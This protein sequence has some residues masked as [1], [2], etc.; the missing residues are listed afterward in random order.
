ME[1]ITAF[2]DSIKI[3]LTEKNILDIAIIVGA[4]VI[5]VVLALR[6]KKRS[7]KMRELKRQR[8]ML[9]ARLDNLVVGKKNLTL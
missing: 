3:Y 2:L 7:Q 5:F 8:K 1:I 4:I 6:Y 9:N